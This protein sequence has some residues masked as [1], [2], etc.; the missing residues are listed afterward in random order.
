VP[1]EGDLL[2]LDFDPQAGHEQA[3]R[4]PALVISPSS[5]NRKTSLAYVCPITTKIKG[6]SSDLAL[7]SGLPVTGVILCSHLRS[8]DWR[9][10]NPKFIG[11]VPDDVLLEARDTVAAIA[12]IP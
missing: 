3:G 4:R 11:R 5:F 10:R 6:Y 7:P 2:W 1:N 12:G 9:V 8:V